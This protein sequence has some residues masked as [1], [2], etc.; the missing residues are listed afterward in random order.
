MSVFQMGG[1][2]PA[3]YGIVTGII[4]IIKF[5]L[6]SVSDSHSLCCCLWNRLRL[7]TWHLKCQAA[8]LLAASLSVNFLPVNAIYVYNAGF[9]PTSTDNKLHISRGDS[10]GCLFATVKLLWLTG[11]H[12]QAIQ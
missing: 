12:F 2:P 6:V 4:M 7:S 8:A 11:V 5:K 10:G 1:T 3:S 9:G